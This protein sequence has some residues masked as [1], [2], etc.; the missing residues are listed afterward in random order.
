MKVCTPCAKGDHYGCLIDNDENTDACA[1]EDA[2]DLAERPL[3]QA[4]DHETL[5]RLLALGGRVPSLDHLLDP[6][7]EMLAASAAHE[8][9]MKILRDEDDRALAFVADP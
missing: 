9:R 1:C 4:Q 6:D 5:G 2:R 8:A 3:A 7:A